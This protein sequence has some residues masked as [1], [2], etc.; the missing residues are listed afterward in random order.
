MFGKCAICGAETELT[1]HHLVPQ[2][3]CRNKYKKLRNDDSN[4]AWICRTCHD[5]VHAVFSEQEL[6]DEYNTI[7][8][9]VTSERLSKFV[10]WKRNHKE[11]VG[12]S[13]MSNNRKGR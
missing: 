12:S 11:F 8:R 4:F 6:R 5:Q 3:A 2:V 7:E 13:K 10:K 9:L 1:K